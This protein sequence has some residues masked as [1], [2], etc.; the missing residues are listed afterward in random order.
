MKN[1]DLIA[2]TRNQMIKV[3]QALGLSHPD[4]VEISQKLDK[5]INQ[6]Q[7]RRTNK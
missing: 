6:E 2:Q 3:G 7:M 5:L 4:T 1:I